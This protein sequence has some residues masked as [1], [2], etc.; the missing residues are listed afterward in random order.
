MQLADFIKRQIERDPDFARAW[1]ESEPGDQV[2]RFVLGLRQQYGLTQ[3]QLAERAGLKR[4]YIARLESGDANPTVTTLHRLA[5][6][7][8]EGLSLRHKTIGSLLSHRLSTCTSR[9][10]AAIIQAKGVIQCERETI[11]QCL[12]GASSPSGLSSE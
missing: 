1:E 9:D 5:R 6:A 3:E 4:S 11:V 8:G 10:S 7:L 12:H 2:A